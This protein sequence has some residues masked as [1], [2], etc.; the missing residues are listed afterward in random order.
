MCLFAAA[1]Q[2]TAIP[3]GTA[4]TSSTS[5]TP[6]TSPSPSTH[7]SSNTAAIAGGV[8]GSIA[9]IVIALLAFLLTRRRRHNGPR[10]AIDADDDKPTR[11][12]QGVA[13]IN[14]QPTAFNI[15][16]EVHGD[17]VSVD[18]MTGLMTSTH[19]GAQSSS[20]ATPSSGYDGTGLPPS[21]ATSPGNGG[22]AI[23]SHYDT[24][25]LTSGMVVRS[26]SEPESKAAQRQAEIARQVQAREE[27]LA[28]LQRRRSSVRHPASSASE[29]SDASMAS[30]VERLKQEVAKL[31]T[32]Q[33]EMLWELNDAPPPVYE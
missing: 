17:M 8:V 26:Q 11:D 3:T 13:G 24:S 28:G 25:M 2:S 6:T 30:E 22:K 15:Y 33:R 19:V 29:S 5:S 31:Q 9:I 21:V 18:S 16:G 14:L 32:Q 1:S 12:G 27:E 20:S 4:A 23:S 7:K 10:V